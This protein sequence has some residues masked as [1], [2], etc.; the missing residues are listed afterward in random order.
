VALL[1]IS[2][3][4]LSA[5]LWV[6]SARFDV[7]FHNLNL[8]KDELEQFGQLDAVKAIN[9]RDRKDDATQELLVSIG[10]EKSAKSLTISS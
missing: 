10:I 6:L 7:C 1:F 8:R 3:P 9:L 5:D 2:R 4:S